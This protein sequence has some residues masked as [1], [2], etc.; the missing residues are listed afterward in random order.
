MSDFVFEESSRCLHCKNPQCKTGCPV[1][2]D[3]PEFLRFAKNGELHKAVQIVGHPFGE[4]CGYVCPRDKQCK[5]HCVLGVKGVPIDVGAVERQAFEKAYSLFSREGNALSHLKVAVV[6]GGVSGVTFASQCYKQGAEVTVFEKNEL[7]HTLKSIPAFRLPRTA[8]ERIISGLKNSGVK[9]EQKEIW[10]ENLA[11]LQR[12]FDVVYLATG[13]TIPNKMNVPG[14]EFA[15]CADTFLRSDSF[16]KTIVV[17]GGNTA[18]DCARL[19]ARS[20]CETIVA[21]RRTRQDMPAFEQEIAQAEAEG[22][23]FCYNLAPVSVERRQNGLEVTFAKTASEG[24]GKLTVTD[25]T[26]KICCDMLVVATGSRFDKRVF[27]AERYIPIDA[28]NRVEE[29]I[30]AGGD[31]AGKSLVAEAVAD[32]LKAAQAVLK[33]YSR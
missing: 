31:A 14:E 23:R 15:I 29:N 4:V 8:V 22:V 6:G 11:A 1:G 13:V 32:G 16:G 21:Y 28:N 25:Q 18:M 12:E 9:V 10:Q 7:L 5:G 27:N 2:Y 19:N 24:R 30:F 20:G 26:E 17:G 3:I 33:E